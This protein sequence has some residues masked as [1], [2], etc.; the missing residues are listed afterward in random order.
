MTPTAIVPLSSSIVY[1]ESDGLPMADNTNQL[2]WIVIQ[3]TPEE[4]AELEQLEEEASA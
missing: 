1:P 4:L 3:A 2:R